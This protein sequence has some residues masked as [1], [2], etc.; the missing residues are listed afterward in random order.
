MWNQVRAMNSILW[1]NLLREISSEGALR[2]FLLLRGDGRPSFRF[3]D[4]RF[5]AQTLPLLGTSHGLLRLNICALRGLV[6][7]RVGWGRKKKKF[8]DVGLEVFRDSGIL[9]GLEV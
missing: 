3:Q 7:P 5:K 8:R 6:S 1:W 9:A 2:S 4:L